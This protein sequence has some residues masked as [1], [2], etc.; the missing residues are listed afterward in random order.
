MPPECCQNNMQIDPQPEVLKLSEME[1][2]LVARNIQFQKIHVKPTSRYIG[3][4]DKIINVPVPE[5]S[6]INT[7]LS[8]PRTPNEAGLIGVEIKRKLSYTNTHMK[9]S[10]IPSQKYLLHW[11]TLKSLAI[12]ITNFTM[13]STHSKKGV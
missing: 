2:S 11:I 5:E 8:L 6:V 9:A 3:V 1:V 13:T 4:S 7:I 12:R 10:L